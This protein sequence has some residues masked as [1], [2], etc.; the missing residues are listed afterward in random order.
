MRV[1]KLANNKNIR[2]LGGHYQG[3]HVKENMLIR[4]RTLNIVD[5]EEQ[6]IIIDKLHIRNIIDLRSQ[7]ERREKPD[8]EIPGIKYSHMVIF[9][10][11]K[12]GITREAK[13]NPD[14]KEIFRNMPDMDILYYEMLHDECLDNI[15]NII[16]TIVRAKE[17]DY[18]FYFHCS[19]GKDRTGIIAAILL[20]MLGVSRKEIVKEYKFTNK[21]ANKKA[22][23]YY[24]QI[25]Y[26]KFDPKFAIKV[27]RMNLA[28][29]KYINVLFDVID[30]EYGS[31]IDFFKKGLGLTEVD[32][33]TFKRRM[34]VA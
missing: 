34:I 17:E 18:A 11:S 6:D 5:K 20:L 13:Q 12:V 21:V 8:V 16:Q 3:V 28:K 7:E 31:E 29:E 1:I 25:K 14:K 24:M 33:E 32:I 22:F 4:G 15:R 10:D 26:L 9:E 2:D 27:G 30:K 19:E 23:R